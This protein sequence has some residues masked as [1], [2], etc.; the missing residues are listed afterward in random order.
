M[1]CTLFAAPHWRQQ[2]SPDALDLLSTPT[3]KNTT[4][5]AASLSANCWQQRTGTSVHSYELAIFFFFRQSGHVGFSQRRKQEIRPCIQAKHSSYFLKNR[6]SSHVCHV[7]RARRSGT[8]LMRH[9]AQAENSCDVAPFA[10]KPSF[11][12]KDSLTVQLAVDDIWSW[13]VVAAPAGAFIFFQTKSHYS[14][15]FSWPQKR[16]FW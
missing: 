11:H 4:F 2:L 13:G 9:S 5:H 16:Y 15:L 10:H 12:Q 6:Q 8:G 7:G 3:E 14:A 1:V